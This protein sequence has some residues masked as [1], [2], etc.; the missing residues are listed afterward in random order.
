MFCVAIY[1]VDSDNFSIRV[2]SAQWQ[3]EGLSI[4]SII[5][6]DLTIQ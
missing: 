3:T 2:R 5:I 6:V 1:S 4:P